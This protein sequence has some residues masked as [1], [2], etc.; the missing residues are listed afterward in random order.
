MNQ[1]IILEGPDGSGKTVLAEELVNRFGFKY[2][3]EG[4]PK[5]EWTSQDLF[6]HYVTTL[7]KAQR[8]RQPMVLDR[9][10]LG[11]TIYGP[12]MRGK[13]LL[14]PD[15][16]TLIE[17]V[18]R[19][20][21][22]R[23]V[24]CLPHWDVVVK[25]WL[26]KKGKDY[27]DKSERLHTIYKMYCVE[28]IDGHDQ[29]LERYDYTRGKE[30][31]VYSKPELP[32]FVL[33]SPTADVLLVGERVNT[34]LTQTDWAFFALNGSSGYL[35]EALTR[36][37]IPENR[38]ALMNAYSPAGTMSDLS[39]VA[40][41]MPNLKRVVALGKVASKACQTQG[42]KHAALPHPSYAKRFNTGLTTY[43]QLLVEAT[44]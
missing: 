20:G 17:R 5:P 24:I 3:H 16:V 22:T 8:S 34:N 23:V 32:P 25:N 43:V 9:H 33:G 21:G 14:T 38:I 26:N 29:L 36:A 4:Q 15:Q 7:Y 6:K 18:V 11:E 10:Y 42:I 37:K 39:Y 40:Q 1:V 35:N 19:A 41:T 12:V 2:Q 27:V 30:F 44:Q 13:S 28:A 31:K